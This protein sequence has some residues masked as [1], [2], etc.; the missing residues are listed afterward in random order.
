M[1]STGASQRVYDYIIQKIRSREWEP[2]NKIPTEA[3]LGKLLGTS[4]LPVR[5][6]LNRLTALGL[7]IRRHGSGSYVSEMNVGEIIDL[8]VPLILI[9]KEDL[10]SVLEFRLY[11]ETGNIELFMQNHTPEAIEELETHCM[12]MVNNAD[13]SNVFSLEDFYFHRSIA[14]GTGNFFITRISELL[15][16]VLIRHQSQLNQSIGPMV[17]LEY[18]QRI[19]DAIKSK[20]KELAILMMRRHIEATIDRISKMPNIDR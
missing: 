1:K 10:L 9:E 4:R 18:H 15:T 6:A 5:E 13:S 19:L 3:E 8:V 20:D 14:R 7:L 2:G 17:G 16:S 11:F 12:N